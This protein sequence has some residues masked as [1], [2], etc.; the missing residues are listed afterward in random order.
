M[1]IMLLASFKKLVKKINNGLK[2]GARPS[3]SPWFLNIRNLFPRK[4]V[5]FVLSIWLQGK[6]FQKVLNDCLVI[7]NCLVPILIAL[8]DV[9]NLLIS[10]FLD[11]ISLFLE[12][13]IGLYELDI[14]VRVFIIV[15]DIAPLDRLE[16]W[17]FQNGTLHHIVYCYVGS[18]S[19]YC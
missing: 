15:V 18:D 6:F 1:L 7:N 9:H 17:S 5:F 10:H 4:V 2:N 19:Y 13:L 14:D 16:I 8:I 12:N 3:N 11:F